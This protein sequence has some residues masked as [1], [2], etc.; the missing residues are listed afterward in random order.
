LGIAYFKTG[1]KSQSNAFLNEL[2]SKSIKPSVGSPSYFAATVYTA[3]DQTD[4]AL[5]SLQK[6]YTDHEVE[7]TWLKVDPLFK[8]LHGDPRFENL[9]RKVGFE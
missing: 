9:L 5:Q 6:A 3:M 4:K 1:R 7:M 8:P 2:S